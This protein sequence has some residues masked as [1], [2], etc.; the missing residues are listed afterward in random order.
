[1]KN[2]VGINILKRH[3]TAEHGHLLGIEKVLQFR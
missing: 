1:V 2:K 3:C